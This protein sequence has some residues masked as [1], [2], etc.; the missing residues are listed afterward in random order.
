MCFHAQQA[1]EKALKGVLID[2]GVTPPKTHRLA[3]LIRLLQEQGVHVPSGVEGCIE[4]SG[5][6]VLTRYPSDLAHIE[7]EE[8]TWA[9]QLAEA[10]VAWAEEQIG[11]AR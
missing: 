11:E 1:S 8:Y 5:Y 3:L 4:L 9:V 10:V 6:A 2:R 7:E